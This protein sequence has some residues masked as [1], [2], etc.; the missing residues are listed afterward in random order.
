M[1]R[2]CLMGALLVAFISPVS[3]GRRQ[4]FLSL[5][6]MS[7]LVLRRA[8]DSGLYCAGV[9]RPGKGRP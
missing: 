8:E 2:S 4:R 3:G 5:T 7:R 9:P 6:W 1:S